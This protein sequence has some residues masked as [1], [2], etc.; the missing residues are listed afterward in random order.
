MSV[1]YIM[2]R[3][4]ICLKHSGVKSTVTSALK[5][6]SSMRLAISV[7][8]KKLESPLLPYMRRTFFSGMY[9]I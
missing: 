5:D 8:E 7:W 9:F 4:D 6:I 1:S 3:P 2:A